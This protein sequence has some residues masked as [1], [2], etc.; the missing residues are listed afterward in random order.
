MST[1]VTSTD[2]SSWTSLQTLIA[3]ADSNGDGTVSE[4]ELV[5]AVSDDSSNVAAAIVTA[6][7][8]DGDG[9]VSL[10]EFSNFADTFS[11]TTGMALLSAQEQSSAV[12][13]LFTGMDADGSATLDSD[14][15]AAGLTASTDSTDE[16]EETAET[17]EDTSTSTS[18]DSEETTVSEDVQA[19]IDAIDTNGD[20]VFDKTDTA[21]RVLQAAGDA[22]ATDDDDDLTSSLV[23]TL[24]SNG[25]GSLSEEELKAAGLA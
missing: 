6:A 19:L 3:A 23:T 14:E 21:L 11:A 4:S 25:D 12:V 17:T 9:A 20:G 13:S 22:E 10:M 5:S 8:S 1:T 24:D 15:L 7:D 18:T 16:S 2:S